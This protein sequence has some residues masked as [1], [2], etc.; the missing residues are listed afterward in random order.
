MTDAQ[1]DI[2]CRSWLN[3][4]DATFWDSDEYSALK[5]V[6]LT[7]VTAKWWNLLAEI[8]EDWQ[9]VDVPASNRTLDLPANTQK[10]LRIEKAETG[11]RL[12]YV[13]RNEI[14]SWARLGPG[15]PLGWRFK[16]GKIYFFPNT[17]AALAAYVRVYFMPRAVAMADLPECLH[18]VMAL[19]LVIMARLKDEK[20]D[21]GLILELRRFE[22]AAM[23]ELVQ[24]Q[25][26]EPVSDRDS[27]EDED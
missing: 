16:G 10:I 1:F 15:D 20:V 17:G 7:V 11:E 18:P 14:F 21:Q 6:S 24:A 26:Q 19:E 22:D 13:L 9:D 12:A 8:K 4:K 5:A 2:L 3:D 27:Y 23:K 25:T